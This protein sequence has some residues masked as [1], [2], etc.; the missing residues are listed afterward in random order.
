[1]NVKRVAVIFL[2]LAM[3]AGFAGPAL[4]AP[5][6]A[7]I[8]SGAAGVG[9]ETFSFLAAGDPQLGA[10]SDEGRLGAG[11]D[12]DSDRAGWRGALLNAT[13][14]WDDF[15]F[16]ITVG[17][18]LHR[19]RNEAQMEA[20]FAP[21]AEVGLPVAPVPGNHDQDIL[22]GLDLPNLDKNGNYW[23]TYGGVLFM[24]INS[25]YKAGSYTGILRF[26]R[27]ATR[28][29][30]DAQWK[31]VT[32]HHSIYSAISRSMEPATIVRRIDYT[33]MFDH[34]GIDLALMGHDHVYTR[35]KPMRHMLPC[36]QGI[37]Y[38][39]M[40]SASGN[41]YTMPNRDFRFV[42]VTMQALAPTLT[43]VTVTPGAL[44][45]T[46]FRADTMETLDEFQINKK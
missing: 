38:V 44:A 22:E 6:G 7:A 5:H 24:H 20:F 19:N 13:S 9:V 28:A 10:G 45:L 23:Y 17:D 21:I 30:K 46:T 29:N 14:R 27:S 8:V 43:R 39:S 12:L 42:A 3:L 41:R 26:L 2:V 16:L 33:T 25:V 35:T 11:G 4:A 40:N 36:E 32:F 1:M 18:Q 37:T 15:A 34:F 31:I